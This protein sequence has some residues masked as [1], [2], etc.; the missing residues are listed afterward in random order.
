[1]EKIYIQ[2]A[3]WSRKRLSE[4]KKSLDPLRG[5]RP[6]GTNYIGSLN[7][8]EYKTTSTDFAGKNKNVSLDL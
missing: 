7:D 1:M 2:Q 4:S 8:H 3:K 6:F 5:H